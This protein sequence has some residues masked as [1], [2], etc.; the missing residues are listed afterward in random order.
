MGTMTIEQINVPIIH[1]YNLV[2]G[3]ERWDSIKFFP[4]CVA[5]I[6]DDHAGFSVIIDFT[7][8][9]LTHNAYAG[10]KGACPFGGAMIVSRN[11]WVFQGALIGHICNA[12]LMNA[13]RMLNDSDSITKSVFREMVNFF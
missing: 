6:I 1:F 13:G 12:V 8:W 2:I 10:F 4:F 5:C 11:V 3:P 7:A 9:V